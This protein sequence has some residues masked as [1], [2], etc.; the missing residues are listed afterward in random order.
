MGLC[1]MVSLQSAD[2]HALADLLLQRAGTQ[3]VC[4]WISLQSQ[5]YLINSVDKTKYSLSFSYQHSTTVSPET[6]PL[7][8]CSIVWQTGHENQIFAQIQQQQQQQNQALI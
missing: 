6:N 5:I 8:F 2:E 1:K 4:F 3:N 7:N